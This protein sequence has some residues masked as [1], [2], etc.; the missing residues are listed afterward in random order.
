[1]R[2]GFIVC[3]LCAFVV[4]G[5]MGCGSGG[6]T[7]AKQDPVKATEAY[8]AAAAPSG[9]IP[10]AHGGGLPESYPGME[11][12]GTAAPANAVPKEGKALEDMYKKKPGT[13]TP[14]SPG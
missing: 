7:T 14:K 5:F 8:K 12:R 6:S 4:F 3:C 11:D 2:L 1:M 9:A 10:D 13:A